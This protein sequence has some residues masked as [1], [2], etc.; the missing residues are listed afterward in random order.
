MKLR[1]R[2]DVYIDNLYVKG[3]ESGF[4][5]ICEKLRNKRKDW[6]TNSTQDEYKEYLG[7]VMQFETLASMF[8]L[9]AK[10]LVDHYKH[11]LEH[12]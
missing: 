11:I 8:F 12:K 4:S 3:I 10:E 9:E 5:E 1:D 2:G 7:S 6:I